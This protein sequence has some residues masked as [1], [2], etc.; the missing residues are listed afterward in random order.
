MLCAPKL[1]SC[2][3]VHILL[4]HNATASAY[5]HMHAAAIHPPCTALL[6]GHSD[7]LGRVAFHPMGHHLASASFDMTWRLWDCE[8]GTCLLEQ[9]GHSRAV[10]A[11]AFQQDGAL[12]GS[13][14]LDAIG[15]WCVW[16]AWLLQGPARL[17]WWCYLLSRC[18]GVIC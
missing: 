9:E 17:L 6:Q 3:A 2:R 8:R 1:H 11:V 15:T 10:Y 4:Q 7:R 18:G 16:A 14:G 13:V 5:G 12:A